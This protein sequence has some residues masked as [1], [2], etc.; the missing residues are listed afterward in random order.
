MVKITGKNIIVTG[1]AGFIG[2]NLVER[3]CK[4]NKVLVVDTLMTGSEENLV[5]ARKSGN[6]TFKKDDSK[7][8]GRHGFKAEIVFHLGMYSASPMYRENPTRVAEVIEGMISVLEY[9]R[10]NSSQ[11]VFAS[12]SSIYNGVAPPHREDIFPKVTDYYTEGRVGAERM[13]ELYA[14]LY[15][16]NTAAMRFF[17]VY[18]YHEEAKNGYANLVTQF[19]WA[20]R[21]GEQPVIYGDGKQRRDFVFV[22]DVV[23]ALVKASETKGFDVFNVGTGKNYSLN[24]M[25]E[26]VNKALGKEIKPKYVKMPV[27]NYVMETLADTKKAERELGF[28]A[29]VSLDEGIG[30]LVRE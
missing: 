19:I 26:K 23:D 22:S 21:K 4:E 3:L 6:V 28:K 15:S 16:V 27:P 24:E 17:S 12:T 9:A 8:I 1:G 18:G 5:E 14:R 13:A 20:M 11:V 30:K 29:S 25:V 7:N 10:K 2:S